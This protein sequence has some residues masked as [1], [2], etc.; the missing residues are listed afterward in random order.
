MK[1]IDLDVMIDRVR[2]DR[3]LAEPDLVPVYNAIIDVLKNAKTQET[4]PRGRCL[5]RTPFVPDDWHD[6]V[7]IAKD[8]CVGEGKRVNIMECA[9]CGKIKVQ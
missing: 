9:S 6:W 4:K 8:V 3:A 1:Q 7:V 5:I 2:A